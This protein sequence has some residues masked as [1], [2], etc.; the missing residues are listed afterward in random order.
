MKIIRT[1]KN[2]DSFALIKQNLIHIVCPATAG[3]TT[4]DAYAKSFISKEAI[5]KFV[6]TTNNRN[7]VGTL[8]PKAMITAFPVP[9]WNNRNNK[10]DANFYFEHLIDIIKL[11]NE[12][13][14]LSRILFIF[15]AYGSHF[16]KEI[17]IQQLEIIVN[18]KDIFIQ[19][20]QIIIAEQ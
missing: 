14:K 4:L 19:A 17:A 1:A 13:I 12:Y 6:E 8:F 2:I 10:F 7:E 15:N 5:Y 16:D 18:N 3:F 11:H 20:E 9:E